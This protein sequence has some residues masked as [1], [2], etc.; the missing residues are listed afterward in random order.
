MHL[1]PR[2]LRQ[3][4]SARWDLTG[5][6]LTGVAAGGVVVAQAFII[7][8]II[9][10]VFLS[11][12]HLEDVVG[13]IWLYC[14]LAPC[15][16]GC[17]WLGEV[18]AQRGASVV[19]C[20]LRDE[21]MS[22]LTR[23]GPAYL[24]R[25]RTGELAAV[26]VD[27][28]EDLDAYFSQYLP[29]VVRAFLIPCLVLAFVLPLD[30]LSGVI[31]ILTAP[32]IPTFALLIGRAAQARNRA[33][34]VALGRLSARFLDAIQGLATLKLFGRSAAQADLIAQAS[35]QFKKTTMEVLRVAFLSAFV[36]ELA[37]TL[38][39][40]VV[41]VQVGLRLLYGQLPFEQA[42]LVLILAP[43]FY[44]P[45]R[46]LGGAFH[47]GM[48]GQ[49]AAGR[50][51]QILA[52]EARTP[53]V[54]SVRTV[55]ASSAPPTIRFEDVSFS[56]QGSSTPA[57]DGISF[58][59]PAGRHVALVGRS[60][61]GKSTIAHLMMRFHEPSAGRIVWN[62][63]PTPDVA[64]DAWRSRIAWMPQAPAMFQGSIADNIGMARQEASRRDIIRAADM[65][66]AHT[67][68]RS[69][70]NGY[71][72][73]VGEG[74]ATLSGGQLQRIALARAFLRDSP[75]L[76]LDEPTSHL[77]PEEEATVRHTIG[78]LMAQRTV[79]LIAHSLG[80]VVNADQVLLLEHGRILER[81]TH[82]SLLQAEGR[83][84]GLVHAHSGGA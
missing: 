43:E 81:G 37:A 69:L 6:V 60:G 23:L 55:A 61:A 54:P 11:N 4:G 72:T 22:H 74:G 52:A 5:A 40:A 78:L 9:N 8:R 44:R 76:V 31:L 12:H 77:D 59:I 24:R 38:S 66:N 45:L 73:T 28:V 10:D 42:L 53:E 36:L 29:Q 50:L 2:L 15:R 79:L 51:F 35:Q 64:P 68:I 48:P 18:L 30:T 67:F 32:L 63:T 57:L 84:A 71:D 3:A 20:R 21:A 47:A 14:V 39:T 58:D 80:N 49:E 7:S 1:D 27:G 83:Y 75:L 65:A 70:P 34:W 25:E 16:A 56:Y 26:L 41:A 46:A 19:K 82:R 62:D 13:W 17:V 33:R